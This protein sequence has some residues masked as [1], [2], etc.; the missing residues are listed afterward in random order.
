MPKLFFNLDFNEKNKIK[1][2]GGLSHHCHCFGIT[3]RTSFWFRKK[4]KN[5]KI[6]LI[7]RIYFTFARL[8]PY[9]CSHSYGFCRQ[10]DSTAY[11][12]NQYYYYF[13]YCQWS[14]KQI[15]L[16]TVY[17]IQIC[18]THISTLI[19]NMVQLQSST[20]TN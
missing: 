4:K 3:D 9:V 2:E 10:S 11:F 6:Q 8:Q 19:A 5:E 18:W 1:N 15:L 17:L 14:S 20:D 7:F 13:I 12:M 16:S